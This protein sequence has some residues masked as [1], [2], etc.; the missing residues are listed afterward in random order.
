MKDLFNTTNH[1][2]LMFNVQN[3][4][5]FHIHTYKPDTEFEIR[6]W[7]WHELFVK[8]GNMLSTN[9]RKMFPIT[10]IKGQL[11]TVEHVILLVEHYM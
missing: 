7:L 10:E 2:S 6:C 3:V 1:R 4:H 5:F 11:W 9:E 8:S